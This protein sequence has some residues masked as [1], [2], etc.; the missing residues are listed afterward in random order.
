MH[1][2]DVV[3]VF[4]S[5]RAVGSLGAR[6]LVPSFSFPTPMFSHSGAFFPCHRG[7]CLCSMAPRISTGTPFYPA[8]LPLSILHSPIPFRFKSPTYRRLRSF[9]FLLNRRWKLLSYGDPPPASARP[10]FRT[11]HGA[12]VPTVPFCAPPVPSVPCFP[13]IFSSRL[14]SLATMKKTFTRL[15]RLCMVHRDCCTSS[16]RVPS[17]DLLS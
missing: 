9:F 4:C 2:C 1:V 15:S 13:G 6:Q 8:R 11:Q 10:D 12:C 5:L 16:V 3:A 7:F 17:F 14:C